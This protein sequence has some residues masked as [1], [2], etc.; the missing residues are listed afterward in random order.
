MPRAAINLLAL[1]RVHRLSETSFKT[2]LSNA[3]DVHD[4]PP[5]GY[6]MYVAGLAM[7]S[8]ARSLNHGEAISISGH[9]VRDA[10]GNADASVELER[11]ESCR[12]ITTL[13]AKVVQDGA[14]RAVFAGTF[15][16][17]SGDSL[18]ELP[19]GASAPVLPSRSACVPA[20]E[21]LAASRGSALRIAREVELYAPPDSALVRHGLNGVGAGE[22]SI[23]GWAGFAQTDEIKLEQLPFFCDA[24]PP[25]IL[26]AYPARRLRTLQLGVHLRARPPFGD[27]MLRVRFSSRFV[28]GGMLEEDGEVWSADGGRLLAQSRQLLRLLP[29]PEGD[30]GQ[31]GTLD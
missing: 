20:M 1:Q 6:L 29:E 31:G 30:E 14:C 21:Q 24:F 7:R 17:L 23:E 9:Y 18:P 28:A 12:S 13:Q 27:T 15:G 8:A 10:V 11:A 3:F 25:P 2:R 16:K 22:T 4:R 5:G 19:F 26:N